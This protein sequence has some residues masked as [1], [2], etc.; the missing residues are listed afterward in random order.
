MPAQLFAASLARR[1]TGFALLLAPLLLGA[2]AG[3]VDPPPPAT[4]MEAVLQEQQRLQVRRVEDLNPV[5]ARRE[6]HLI[7][8]ARAVRNVWGLPYPDEE[9]PRV[10]DI[11][12]PGA[13]GPLAARSYA[14]K[15]TQGTPA[16]LMF[17]TGGWARAS[18]DASDASARALAARTGAV[19]VMVLPRAAP[20]ARFPAAHEDALSAYA[21]A[22]RGGLRG[23]G[24]DPSRLVLAGEG[25]GGTL[26]L[27]TALQARARGLGAP[28]AVLLL[29]PVVSTQPTTAPQRWDQDHYASRD[30]QADPRLDPA[31][32]AVLQGL[33]PVLLVLSER[34]PQA[35]AVQTLV[36]RLHEAGVP[37]RSQAYAGTVP[38]FF[39]LGA[40]VEQ[41]RQAEDWAAA[42]LRPVLARPEAPPPSR[43]AARRQ[44]RR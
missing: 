10:Q 33:P 42:E 24:A 26:A 25:T 40:V 31:G 19:V 16:V 6:P 13:G 27:S 5:E 1:P 29:T 9:V 12:V 11:Q 18:L 20:E 35:P 43:R 15:E 4:G 37:V 23:L 30:E 32:R 36:A 7:D 41:A 17:P 2:C 3:R 34:D 21:W 39:G 38:E 44:R 22:L 28:D 14:P 8:A